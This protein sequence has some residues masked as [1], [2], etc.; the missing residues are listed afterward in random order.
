MEHLTLFSFSRY[1]VTACKYQEVITFGRIYVKQV[2]T[3]TLIGQ[4]GDDPSVCADI[5]RTG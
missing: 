1:P 5:K 4:Y 2:Q 3:T